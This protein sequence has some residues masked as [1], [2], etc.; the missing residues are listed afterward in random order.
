MVVLSC[1]QKSQ[2]LCFSAAAVMGHSIY[3]TSTEQAPSLLP[4]SDM[5]CEV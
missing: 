5:N 3:I 4:I 2:L 1:Q